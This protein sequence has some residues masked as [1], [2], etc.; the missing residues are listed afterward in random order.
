MDH[1]Q[2]KRSDT[3]IWILV[4]VLALAGIGV[5]L[6]GALTLD[7]SAVTVEWSTASELDT[8][9]FNLLRGES[10]DGPFEQVNEALIPSTGDTL[11][12][13]S[14]RY[15]D[16]T[17]IAGKTYYYMLEEIES[18]GNSNRH[19]PITV[20]A[21]NA[22]KWELLIGGLLVIGAGAYAFILRRD[23]ARPAERE[24]PSTRPE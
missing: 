20:Q 24:T 21:S 23:A 5:A 16:S 6:H 13:G 14:Y 19:G 22:A 8:V 17:V 3:V 1:P 7:Q 2:Q 4:A 11:T 18:N 12:G 9:G 15:E 10:P